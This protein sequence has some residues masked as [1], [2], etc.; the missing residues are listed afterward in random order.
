[1][2]EGKVNF[3][4]LTS[5]PTQQFS[6][7]NYKQWIASSS[8]L[9]PPHHHSLSTPATFTAFEGWWKVF[10]EEKNRKKSIFPF[11]I[12]LSFLSLLSMMPIKIV[13]FRFLCSWSF[14][15]YQLS[16]PIPALVS[17]WWSII[18]VALSAKCHTYFRFPSRIIIGFSFSS[19]PLRENWM[20]ISFICH[21]F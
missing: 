1:M 11:A 18:P 15:R 19:S 5:T 17:Q 7:F 6:N 3:P 4:T 12:F 13:H 10:V 14:V 8:C 2:D 21:P 16:T 9:L 20:I